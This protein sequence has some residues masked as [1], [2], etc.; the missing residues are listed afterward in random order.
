MGIF[1]CGGALYNIVESRRA[2][3]N[4]W[5]K[6][7]K[8]ISCATTIL[9]SLCLAGTVLAVD[10]SADVVSSSKGAA[11][12]GKIFVTKDKVRMEFP[13]AATITRMDKEI[14][15]VLMPDQK[16]YMEQKFDPNAVAASAEKAPGE[17][18]R[19]YISD[20]VIDGKNAKKYGI[21]Y[22]AAGQE[23]SI[24]QW[25]D[26]ATSI[27]LKTAAADGSWSMEYKNLKAGPQPEALF[28]IPEGYQK[29]SMPNMADMAKKMG[30]GAEE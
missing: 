12:T 29:F 17:I 4:I 8:K 15:W 5:E 7:M 30:S 13:G 24:F 16:M 6:R 22:M 9:I 25:I 18:T 11:A 2:I 10:F 28:E 20:E 27:P 19:A 1:V 3:K 21:T 14:A 23:T 26:P